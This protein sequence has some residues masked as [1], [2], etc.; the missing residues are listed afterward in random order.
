MQSFHLATYLN[1]P[2]GGF[3]AMAQDSWLKVLATVAAQGNWTVIDLRPLRG[4]WYAGKFTLPP[5]LREVIFGFDAALLVGG[6][7]PGT[8]EL[9]EKRE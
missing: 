6:A 9:T 7:E 1:N 3:R 5:E 8:R 4:Y 2:P